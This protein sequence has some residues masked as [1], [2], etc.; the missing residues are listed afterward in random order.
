MYQSCLGIFWGKN[1]T[2]QNLPWYYFLRVEIGYL[3]PPI[4]MS[5]SVESQLPCTSGSL[6]SK[7]VEFLSSSHRQWNPMTEREEVLRR[8]AVRV[9]WGHHKG[10]PI[11]GSTAS[12]K[13]YMFLFIF[14]PIKIISFAFGFF[15]LW[16][17]WVV[18]FLNIWDF[19][20]IFVLLIFS[21]ILLWTE[22]ILWLK[23][24]NIFDRVYWQNIWPMLVNC[25][26]D[27]ECESC[28]LGE[29]VPRC[30]LGQVRGQYVLIGYLS[31]LLLNPERC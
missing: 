2:V 15:F 8:Q 14:I 3:L 28:V 24:L 26:C 22:I 11:T 25:L 7:G 29:R 19:P 10:R 6:I 30:Q 31:N 12:Q 23:H 17:N 16:P 20:D 21:L 4:F 9:S 1:T 18:W 13:R 5:F 27:L